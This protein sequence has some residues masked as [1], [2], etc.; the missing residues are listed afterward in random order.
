MSSVSLDWDDTILRDGHPLHE[1][2]KLKEIKQLFINRGVKKSDIKGTKANLI[3]S[4]KQ[5]HAV[6]L[7]TPIPQLTVMQIRLE[8]RLLDIRYSGPV[9]KEGFIQRL[10]DGIKDILAPQHWAY[11]DSECPCTPRCAVQISKNEFIFGTSRFRDSRSMLYRYNVHQNQWNESIEYPHDQELNAPCVAF[12]KKNKR[13]YIFDPYRLELYTIPLYQRLFIID[14]ETHEQKQIK[15]PCS[16]LGCICVESQ[17]H[18]IGTNLIHYIFDSAAETFEQCHQLS[19]SSSNCI[20]IF[21]ISA[22][23]QL[24][25]IREYNMHY[26]G[27]ESKIWNIISTMPVYIRDWNAVALTRDQRYAVFVKC[28]I[29]RSTKIY[30]MDLRASKSY[31]CNIH[32]PVSLVYD[33]TLFI[34]GDEKRER[35][36]VFGYVRRCWNEYDIG[37][38]I[39]PPQYIVNLIKT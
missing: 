19:V 39:F 27:L 7:T 23:R 38:D 15:T 24:L 5:N 29:Y 32:G 31:L 33:P 21:Y 10:S 16:V 9:R 18:L 13:V 28:D 34:V 8:L 11:I 3:Q 22:E 20:I 1:R 4:L 36:T 2:L 17:L 12:N 30:V 37:L 25:V 35:L 6:E 14:W 26:Y